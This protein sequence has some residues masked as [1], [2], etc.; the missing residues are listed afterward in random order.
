M[1]YIA[2]DNVLESLEYFIGLGGKVNSFI[3]LIGLF[4]HKKSFKANYLKTDM[5]AFGKE[6]T[7]ILYFGDEV[8]S[9]DSDS[10]FW[11]TLFQHNWME[12]VQTDMLRGNKISL[13]HAAVL[14][15]W[16]KPF[17]STSTV[18]SQFK[19]KL[20]QEVVAQF[21]IE[22]NLSLSLESAVADKSAVYQK[23][24]SESSSEDGKLTLSFASGKFQS[25]VPSDLGGAPFSQTL[26]SNQEFK[27]AFIVI[28]FDFLETYQLTTSNASSPTSGWKTVSTE[29]KIRDFALSVFRH[30]YVDRWL[31][32]V[33]N[34]STPSDGKIDDLPFKRLKFDSFTGLIGE[35]SHKQNKTSLSSS[36]GTDIRFF[37]EPIYSTDTQFFYFTTQWNAGNEH[38]LSF[39]SL[40]TYFEANF[41]CE[42]VKEN[43]VFILKVKGTVPADDLV[44]LPKPFLLLAGI[45]GTGKTRFVKEQAGLHD[46]D[47]NLCIVPVRPDWHE[48]SDLLGYVSRINTTPE[49]ISTKVLGFIIDAWKKIAPEAS[50]EGH[51]QLNW[52]SPPYWLCLDEM[53]L[54]PVEQ[55]F[56][57]YLSVLESRSFDGSRYSCEALLDEALL[58]HSHMRKD[59]GLLDATYDNLWAYFQKEGIGLPP[60]LIVAGT[61]NMDETTHSFS[62]K[63]IDRAITIDFGEFFSNDFDKIFG[64]QHK[65]KLFTYGQHSAAPV[66]M[67]SCLADIDGKKTIGF[68][69]GI[70]DILKGT[71]FELAYRALNELLLMVYNLSPN[72]EVTLQAVWDDFLMTKV[73]PRIDGDEDKLRSLR[74]D[75]NINILIELQALLETE[76]NGIW[77]VEKRS[78]LFAVNFDGKPIDDIPCRSEKKIKWMIDRLDRNTFTSF[79]P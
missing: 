12:Y 75:Q 69:K 79:W 27:K 58:K 28:S 63:V 68:L 64:E 57:D 36:E 6:F 2:Q 78:D 16:R 61:V 23:L 4:L 48:P 3:G 38:P 53:N 73:L 66:D 32:G 21:F 74:S 31:E 70:N 52:D 62:R 40:K 26:Y 56:A 13:Q 59:L 51:G 50:G 77:K 65:P 24:L 42:L 30:F 5:T 14:F 39:A 49:Y 47:G 33:I 8:Q 22:E 9:E 41:P 20:P 15:S 7:E 76:L 17:D 67:S 55:Y 18:I 35:F 54:A 10:T 72:E 43:G 19:R 1:K 46:I 60:N 45:S 71:P 25:K 11:Y 44:V 34:Q 37:E 29:Q